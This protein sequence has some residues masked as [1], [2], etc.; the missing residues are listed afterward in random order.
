M[1]INYV[2]IVAILLGLEDKKIQEKNFFAK[3][4]KTICFSYVVL[5]LRMTFITNI[6]Q[7][8]VKVWCEDKKN[9][10]DWSD[11]SEFEGLCVCWC[12]PV[13]WI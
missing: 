2:E 9:Q 4:K 6:Q 3:I 13:D 1:L 12:T 5:T 11:G 8:D 7:Q 10:T